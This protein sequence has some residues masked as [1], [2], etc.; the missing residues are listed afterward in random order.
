MLFGLG[1]LELLLLG[2]LVVAL[3]GLHR[4]PK[5]ARDLGRL[6]GTIQRLKRRHP[7]LAHLPWWGR[8]FR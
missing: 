7:W 6:H 8:F 3:F 1:P 4:A 2:G 5:M